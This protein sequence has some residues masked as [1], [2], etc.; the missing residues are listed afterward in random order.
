MR[1]KLFS[2]LKVT[3]TL[4][5]SLVVSAAPL[6]PAYATNY[7][8]KKP[9]WNDVCGTVNDTFTL[10][11]VNSDY[12]YKYEVNNVDAPIADHATYNAWDYD[13]NGNVTIELYEKN[14]TYDWV[15]EVWRFVKK[16]IVSWNKQTEWSKTYTNVPCDTPDSDKISFCHND[17][18]L[19]LITTSKNAFYNAGHT[20]L[21]DSAHTGD[22][23]PAGS[24][25]KQ[26]QTY[27]WAARG[28]QSLL[29]TDCKP[30]PG[31]KVEVTYTQW[32]DG[33][34]KC[35][36]TTVTQTRTKTTTTTPYKYDAQTKTWVLDTANASSTSTT[37]TQQRT[38]TTAE[39][40]TCNVTPKEPYFKDLCGTGWD[41]FKISYTK[42]VT[43]KADGN[44]VSPGWHKVSGGDVVTISAEAKA[45]YALVNYTGPWTYDFTDEKCVDIEKELVGWLDTNKDGR[46][47]AGDQVTWKITVTNLGVNPYTGIDVSVSDPGA[48]LDQDYISGL[49]PQ[50]SH[51]FTATTTLTA[52]DMTVCKV[53]N[54]ASFVAGFNI[55]H[56]QQALVAVDAVNQTP[57]FQFGNFTGTSNTA[58]WEFTCPP[59]DDGEVLGDSTTD[60]GQTLSISTEL[61]E[62]LPATGGEANPLSILIAALLAYGATYFIQA[63]RRLAREQA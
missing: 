57:T 47:S 36:D 9:T 29:L 15:W 1:G 20:N 53:T 21:N 23:Y 56:N 52:Q 42:G 44:V 34:W 22:V 4:V 37:E 10:P 49:M 40:E 63:R 7:D 32:Q 50:D 48:V 45:D 12:N 24:I 8:S 38:L 58:S 13:D 31:N 55:N 54:S 19:H 33:D 51:S 39:L 28:D 18:N 41:W 17:N 30:Q 61:P 16:E 43:Y 46:I 14:V 2:G 26:G 27:S 60:G 6:T 3:V 62:A 59:K 5:M 11:N 25:V 35:G